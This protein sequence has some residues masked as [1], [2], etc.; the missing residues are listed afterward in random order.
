MFKYDH[1][2]KL[3]LTAGFPK[4]ITVGTERSDCPCMQRTEPPRTARPPRAR[5]PIAP[6]LQLGCLCSGPPLPLSRPTLPCPPPPRRCVPGAPPRPRDRAEKVGE[7]SRRRSAAPPGAAA[8]P[9][10]GEGAAGAQRPLRKRRTASSHGSEA[11]PG[12]GDKG[13]HAASA[14]A[15]LA[16]DQPHPGMMRSFW[17]KLWNQ[18]VTPQNCKEPSDQPI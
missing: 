10:A 5:Q 3:P 18:A 13:L 6:G 17:R 12:A 15:G 1:P 16:L 11:Y 9:P 2:G 14:A 4:P 7:R 8:P